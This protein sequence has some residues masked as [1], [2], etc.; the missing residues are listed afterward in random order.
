MGIV[1]VIKFLFTKEHRVLDEILLGYRSRPEHFEVEEC[2]ISQELA[3]ILSAAE[4]GVVLASLR[5][6][7]DLSQ[8]AA[9]MKKDSKLLGKIPFKFLIFDYTR[10][11]NFQQLLLKMGIREILNPEVNP[12]ALRHKIELLTLAVGGAKLEAP[13]GAGKKDTGPRIDWGPPLDLEDDIWLVDN[14]HTIRNLLSSW[15]LHV[16]GPSPNIGRWLRDS[17]ESWVFDVREEERE[18][19]SPSGGRWRLRGQ[20]IPEIDWDGQFWSFRGSQFELF[21]EA[22]SVR[23]TKIRA[24]AQ[25]ILIAKNSMNGEIKRSFIEE[26]FKTKYVFKSDD[27]GSASPGGDDILAEALETKDLELRYREEVPE[28]KVNDKRGPDGAPLA[29]SNRPGE[30]F[31]DQAL[32]EESEGESLEAQDKKRRGPPK[33]RDAAI[34]GYYSGKPKANDP[35]PQESSEEDG[36]D[37]GVVLPESAGPR[38]TDSSE[39]RDEKHR[40]PSYQEGPI[41][42][43]YS[44]PQK[45]KTASAET[46]PEER[47]DDGTPSPE[48]SPSTSSTTPQLQEPDREPPGYR[49]AP[50]DGY[51]SGRHKEKKTP[52]GK[53]EGD[54]LFDDGAVFSDDSDLSPDKTSDAPDPSH[55]PSS[56]PEESVG[57]SSAGHPE[58]QEGAPARKPRALFEAQS[59]EGGADPRPADRYTSHY[60]GKSARPEVDPEL[61]AF[62]KPKL[63]SPPVLNAT[64]KGTTFACTFYDCFDDKILCLTDRPAPASGAELELQI[65]LE[66]REILLRGLVSSVEEIPGGSAF[67]VVLSGEALRKAEELLIE[68]APASAKAEEY[69]SSVRRV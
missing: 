18:I 32:S 44:G 45:N 43:Y 66:K 60:T 42:G 62:E 22:P 7:D 4:R 39:T 5:S 65:N 14:P 34:D 9:F 47:F 36:F 17:Q 56:F 6:K 27:E 26:S 31:D 59:Q 3:T 48:R 33:Y 55:R 37:D 61:S 40:R 19:F 15:T 16:K 23:V 24:E 68:L 58:F 1:S 25:A 38:S 28:G 10:D 13:A 11:A 29:P 41:D 50:I 54:D 57:G 63:S 30:L 21:F 52:S 67:G 51:Y 64:V 53:G 69:F 12:K 35:R 20:K 46:N 2:R 8:I 49:D